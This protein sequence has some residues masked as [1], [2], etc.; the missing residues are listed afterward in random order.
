MACPTWVEPM[1]IP[2]TIPYFKPMLGLALAY[3]FLWM[4]LEGTLW[5][6]LILA[7]TVVLLAI[8]YLTIRFLGGRTLSSRRFVLVAAAAGL[9]GGVALPFVTI[10]LMALK[11]GIHAHGPEYTAREI[12]W[13]WQQLPLWGTVGGLVGLGLGLVATGRQTA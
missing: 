6:D 5:R 10:F 13:V 7:A 11:T 8:G 1:K 2:P 9:A 4:A 12:A 3:G